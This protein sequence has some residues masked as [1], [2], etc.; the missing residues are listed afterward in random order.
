[1]ISD[2]TADEFA[3]LFVLRATNLAWFLGAGASAP[4]GV[5]TGYDM[6]LDFKAT[7]YTQVIG[8]PRAQIDPTDPIWEARISSHFN[9][10]HGFPPTGAP[11][12]YSVA[13]EGLLGFLWV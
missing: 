6:I 8:L 11:N 5:P 2:L 12:E 9:D 7:L 3:R 13:F 4:A 1:V 10:S